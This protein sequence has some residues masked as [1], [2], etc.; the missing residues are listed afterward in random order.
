MTEPL[1]IRIDDAELQAALAKLIQRSGA[2]SPAL[3]AIGESMAE[4][5]RSR[6]VTSTAPDGSHWAPNSP[7]T[8]A[9]YLAA[10][11]GT[12][13]KGGGLTKKGATLAGSKKP[14]VGSTRLLGNQIVYQVSGSAVQ[15][16]SNRIQAAVQQFGAAARQFGKA[17][18]GA[19]P[20]RPFLGISAGDRAEILETVADWLAGG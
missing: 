20:A 1:G 19:I 6:F 14:L 16:G 3:K 9:R 8:L 11:S 2:P 5:T 10:R 18:W 13:G 17:P 4:S 7:V 12:R 15:I